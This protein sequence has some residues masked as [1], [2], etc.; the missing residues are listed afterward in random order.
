[1]SL[2]TNWIFFVMFL[3]TYLQ[4]FGYQIICVLLGS[5]TVLV[6]ELECHP[7]TWENEFTLWESKI[8]CAEGKGSKC[9]SASCVC[10]NT[11]I[12]QS[13]ENLIHKRTVSSSKVLVGNDKGR[14][15]LSITRP[16]Y[17]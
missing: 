10:S 5:G 2:H 13:V 6:A 4:S 9:F 1:M 14:L 16:N 17:R 11:D 15:S 7:N 3:S 8:G 12:E